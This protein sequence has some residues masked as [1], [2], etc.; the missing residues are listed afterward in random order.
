MESNDFEKSIE[1]YKEKADEI[2]NAIDIYKQCGS[3]LPPI[4]FYNG[5]IDKNTYTKSFAISDSKDWTKTNTYHVWAEGQKAIERANTRHPEETKFV[6]SNKDREEAPKFQFSG[7]LY[8]RELEIVFWK[9]YTG[10]FIHNVEKVCDDL[11]KT[12]LKD[13][14]ENTEYYKRLISEMP[15]K[16]IYLSKLRAVIATFNL[17]ENDVN[18]LPESLRPIMLVDMGLDASIDF[19]SIEDLFLDEI[20]AAD[21]EC[22]ILSRF[23]YMA[24]KNSV[25]NQI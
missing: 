21:V 3:I 6:I 16:A 22:M 2:Q 15:A 13:K 11:T 19:K 12:F 5:G 7:D 23:G 24:I 14:K 25:E 17:D 10:V 8:P 18:C 20:R 4:S 1:K 9:L